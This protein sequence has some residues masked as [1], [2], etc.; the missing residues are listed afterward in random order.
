MSW[1]PQLYKYEILTK[2]CKWEWETLTHLCGWHFIQTDLVNQAALWH[3]L[4]L[5]LQQTVTPSDLLRNCWA[6]DPLGRSIIQIR[7]RMI[8]CVPW[9]AW[10]GLL[11]HVWTNCNLGNLQVWT[12]YHCLRHTISEGCFYGR[13]RCT[14]G[15]TTVVMRGFTLLQTMFRW[16]SWVRHRPF[17]WKLFLTLHCDKMVNVLFQS[18]TLV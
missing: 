15:G 6:S 1:Y 10:N 5:A 3:K 11:W 18:S 4:S 2:K 7:M 17:E 12:L 9:V 16:L 13:V 14:Y 8:H